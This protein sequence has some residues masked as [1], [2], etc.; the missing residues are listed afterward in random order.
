MF[1]ITNLAGGRLDFPFMPTK[2]QPYTKGILIKSTGVGRV[3][4]KLS[5]GSDMELVAISVGASLYE[6]TDYWNFYVN[7]QMICETIYTKDLPEGIHFMAVIPVIAGQQLEFEYINN[8]GRVKDI[9][10]N[11]QL[12]M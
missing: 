9:W 4:R 12:L 7:G 8:G 3:M 6:V 5:F 11:L 10:V 1:N 2:I